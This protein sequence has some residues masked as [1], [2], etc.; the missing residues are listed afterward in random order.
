MLPTTIPLHIVSSRLYWISISLTHFRLMLLRRV[1]FPRHVVA[2]YARAYAARAS[3]K[4]LP[5]RQHAPSAARQES[6]SS[7]TGQ[8]SSGAPRRAWLI[9]GTFGVGLGFYTLQLYLAASKPC[10]NPHIADLAQQ[11]DVAVRYDYTA[12]SFDSDVGLSELLMGINGIRKKLAQKCHGEV[13]EVSCGTGRNL[14]YY[15]LNSASGIVST[16]SFNDLSSQM[17]D[18]CRNKWE[19]IYG[20]KARSG[21]LRHDLKVR[22][23]TGSA[24]EPM[25]LS[26]NG[27]KYDT[28]F[29]TMGLCS[30]AAPLQLLE[31]IIAHLD[32]SKPDSRI[33]LLEHG[34]SYMPWM[35]NILDESAEKHAELHG[36]WFNRDIGQLV[37]EAAEKTGMEIVGERRHHFGTTWVFELKPSDELVKRTSSSLGAP[38][39]SVQTASNESTTWLNRIGWK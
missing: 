38:S 13:L 21:Q 34:R 14:G 20:F 37:Q 39:T 26:P 23:M 7:T 35:N 17:I 4:S 25:P 33:L 27:K 3:P 12:S 6:A 2:P 36:C 31:N 11:K 15:S 9:T 18:V 30:T 5:R 8:T 22:F 24:L 32:T 10:H 16:L 28:I 19:T 29:Q 1:V